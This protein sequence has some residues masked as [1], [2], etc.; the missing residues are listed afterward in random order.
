ML[1]VNIDQQSMKRPGKCIQ[2]E[3]EFTKEGSM[4]HSAKSRPN[5]I[6]LSNRAREQIQAMLKYG[7]LEESRSAY[8]NPVTL[9]VRERKSV[10]ICIDVRRINK[11]MVADR[12]KVK[13]ISEL[14]QNYGAKYIRSLDLNNVFLKVRLEQSS[15]QWA[16]CQFESNVYQFK[17]V[18]MDS[19][20]V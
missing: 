2:F 13:P 19:R 7:I 11:Q 20:T 6:A 8:I 17:K 15:R 4:P 9:V 12:T 5:P 18:R 16:A 1:A 10:R 14:L 3:Y